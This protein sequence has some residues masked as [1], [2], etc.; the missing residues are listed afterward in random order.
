M[1]WKIIGP[2][3]QKIQLIAEGQKEQISITDLSKK[4]GV[5]RKTIYKW[6][7]RHEEEGVDGLKDQNRAPKN[8]PNKT[9]DDIVKLLI[10]E[11]LRIANAVQRKYIIN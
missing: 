6:R 4:Y 8:N 3:D 7:T 9:T 5:S 10:D 1:P 2:M 11:N